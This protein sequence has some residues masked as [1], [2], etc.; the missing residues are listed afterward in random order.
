MSGTSYADTPIV[1]NT[2]FE[3]VHPIRTITLV[4]A[5]AVCAGLSEQVWHSRHA[6]GWERP[7]ISLLRHARPP[8]AH[9]ILLL[10][11]PVPF[12]LATFGLGWIA[13][14]SHKVQLAV[15]GALGCGAALIVTEHL[16]KPL[17][18]RSVTHSGALIFPSG[19]VTAA[20]AWAM[21][22]WLLIAEPARYRFALILIPIAVAW[23]VVSEG[24]HLPADA[25]AGL[26][27]GGLVVYGVVAGVELLRIEQRVILAR[28]REMTTRS[29]ADT[30][31]I[32]IRSTRTFEPSRRI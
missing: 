19:H 31:T 17:V 5:I 9:P 8:L 15:S 1:R 23:T 20:A 22:A 25:I 21:F 18:G 14:R 30:S 26:L 29:N 11:Q 28:W 10:W 16:L 4:A 2:G 3:R 27:V 32:R 12:A 13:Y 7:I 6:V 24:L